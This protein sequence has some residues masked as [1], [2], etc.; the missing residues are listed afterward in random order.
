MA[1]A[2]YGRLS[3]SNGP[4]NFAA[5]KAA[6][7]AGTDAHS[8]NANPN[9]ADPSAG[10]FQETSTSDTIGV[11]LTISGITRDFAGLNRTSPPDI[12]AYNFAHPTVLPFVGQKNINLA[13]IR[14]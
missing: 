5:W 9:L 11:G 7:P 14:Y 6:N 8:L 2:R 12:G 4:I 3:Y 1:E 10:N 13:P